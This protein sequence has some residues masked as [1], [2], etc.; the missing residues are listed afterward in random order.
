[1]NWK[2]LKS[3]KLFQHPRVTLIE[4]EVQ[5]PTGK[6][7]QYLRFENL[8]AGSDVIAINSA[9]KIL[10]QREYNHPVGQVL[11]QFPGGVKEHSESFEDAAKRE[12]MEESGYKAN[13][14]E[15]L[16]FYYNNRRRTSEISKVYCANELEKVEP[17]KE[18]EEQN[19][20][21]LWLTKKEI[22]DLI[23]K[24]EI[25]ASDALAI[26]MLFTSQKK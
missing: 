7:T 22:N 13:N 12:L 10:L 26:W 5:L 17:Q 6:T 18:Q 8:G 24:N 19:I 2:I 14:L 23:I 3:V 1:M 15:Y 9:G 25:V 16:G 20:E 11:W 21:H 4:D